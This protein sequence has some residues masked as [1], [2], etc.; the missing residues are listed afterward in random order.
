MSAC[1]GFTLGVG[2]CHFPMLRGPPYLIE[3]TFHG[4]LMMLILSF[5]YHPG[6][7]LLTNAALVVPPNLLPMTMRRFRPPFGPF[8]GIKPPYEPIWKL[9]MS[10]FVILSKSDMMSSVG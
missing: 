3:L 10:L 2:F 5:L 7:H 1:V 9:R 4:Y 6:P 8:K